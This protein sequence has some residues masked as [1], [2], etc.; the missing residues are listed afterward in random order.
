MCTLYKNCI[1][2]I[3]IITL[4]IIVS[5]VEID[6]RQLQIDRHTDRDK[7]TVEEKILAAN[8]NKKQPLIA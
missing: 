8:E 7:N 5:I 1:Q 2:I 6:V 3:K 4:N